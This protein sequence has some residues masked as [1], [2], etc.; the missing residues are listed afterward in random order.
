[1]IENIDFS[2]KMSDKHASFLVRF[3]GSAKRPLQTVVSVALTKVAVRKKAALKA[4]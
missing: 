2:A 4:D 3:W 1:V